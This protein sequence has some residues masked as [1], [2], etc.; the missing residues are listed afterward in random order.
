M[1][2]DMDFVIIEIVTMLLFLRLLEQRTLIS[3]NYAL[4]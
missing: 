1:F 2:E 4:M 3:Q